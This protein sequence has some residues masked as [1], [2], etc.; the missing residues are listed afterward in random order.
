MDIEAIII[1]VAQVLMGG[2]F[3]IAGLRNMRSFSVLESALAAKNVPFPG[4][5]LGIGIALQIV[6]GALLAIGFWSALAAAGLILFVVLATL[7]F[8]NFWAYEGAERVNHINGFISNMA[9]IG[10]F[11]ALLA[12]AL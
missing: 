3:L 4:V 10:G 7:L 8:H 9:L 1:L 5:S 12:I 11:L 6:C 2:A